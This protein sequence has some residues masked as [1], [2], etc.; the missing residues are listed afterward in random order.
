MA[1][2]TD[3]VANIAEKRG[4]AIPGRGDNTGLSAAKRKAGAA[5]LGEF[6]AVQSAREKLTKEI[7]AARA[8]AKEVGW[9]TKALER[10]Y[11]DD[12]RDQAKREAGDEDYQF[13]RDIL[14]SRLVQVELPLEAAAEPEPPAQA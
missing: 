8:R 6:E 1:E 3:N 2:K 10:A 9:D 13:A 12:L 5:F 14:G 11:R 4:R 7:G